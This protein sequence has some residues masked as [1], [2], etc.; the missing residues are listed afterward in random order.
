MLLSGDYLIFEDAEEACIIIGPEDGSIGEALGQAS[1]VRKHGRRAH[2]GGIVA[3]NDP[4]RS[5]APPR[6]GW[7][8]PGDT[9]HHE[10]RLPGSA[11]EH[12]KKVQ[13]AVGNVDDNRAVRFEMIE[14]S[15]EGL[16]GEQMDGDGIA[17]K[18]IE[19]EQ[20]EWRL[21]FALQREPGVAVDNFDAGLRIS[22]K[23]EAGFGELPDS[24]INLVE[25]EGIS[26][27]AISG[28]GARAQADETDTAI[29]S[30]GE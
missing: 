11:Y 9:D 3:E 24:R 10:T 20:V 6:A 4:F 23:S 28:Q 1:G 15:R 21:G 7:R 2:K 26:G 16:E 29:G 5:G 12:A 14:I 13:M 27:P 22:E 18:R 17:G 8:T 25:P 19:H 30:A